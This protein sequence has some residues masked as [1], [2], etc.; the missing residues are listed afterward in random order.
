MSMQ[1]DIRIEKI[2]LN[3]GA[4]KEQA[5][6]DKGVLLL[7]E[8]SMRTP[9]KTITQKRIAT[10]GLRPGLPIG[11]KVTLRKL[12]AKTM[13]KRLLYAKDN[14]LKKTN[15]DENGNL[16]FGIPEYIDIE[17]AKY[18]PQIGIMGLEVAVTLQKPGSH[19]K[20]RKIK[21]GAIGKRQL[22]KKDEAIAYIQ[23]TF[24]TAIE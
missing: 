4:G 12:E 21:R 8:L 20:K 18:N 7:T 3:I 23:Q 15:F 6:L 10:W 14:K 17:G 16:A 9:V 11:C 24:N 13:L 5:R 19:V 1:N 22:I 2:T